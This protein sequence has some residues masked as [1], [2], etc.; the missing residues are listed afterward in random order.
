MIYI[1]T[2]N[3]FSEQSVISFIESLGSTKKFKDQ[4]TFIVTDNSASINLALFS[5]IS[6]KFT[7]KFLFPNDNLGFGGGH[8]LAFK[9][10]KHQNS[11][12]FVIANNDIEISSPENI[13]E[14]VSAVRPSQIIS[15][16]IFSNGAVWFSGA[17]LSPIF[18]ELVFDKG[19]DELKKTD[20]ITGCFMIMQCGTY[21]ELGGFD[22]AFFMYG[23]DLDLCIR[24]N[25]LRIEMLVYPQRIEHAV[26]SGKSGRY[27]TVYLFHNSRNRVLISL[28]YMALPSYL[29]LCS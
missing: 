2:V 17:K 11:D 20:F 7:I 3:Y 24:A 27:S 21:K 16:T 13:M 23:E 28:K 15:P 14:M 25:K 4:L 29:L 22:D 19:Y 12:V 8:N 6:N 1:S 26:G 10:V 9:S 5:N 18:K